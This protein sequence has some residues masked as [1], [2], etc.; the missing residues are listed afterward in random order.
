MHANAGCREGRPRPRP[1]TRCWH[2]TALMVTESC[3]HTNQLGTSKKT[4]TYII[5]SKNK[6]LHYAAPECVTTQPDVD[7]IALR[8]LL[9]KCFIS[10]H[11]WTQTAGIW[12]AA[13][14][15]NVPCIANPQGVATCA[16]DQSRRFDHVSSK[17]RGLELDVRTSEARPC[18]AKQPRTRQSV[19]VRKGAATEDGTWPQR[20]LLADHASTALR[21]LQLLTHGHDT[22]QCL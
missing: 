22:G 20:L 11:R 14:C 9:E 15:A 8:V 17:R 4:K 18:P 16:W 19:G 6:N 2:E 3:R 7:S 13:Q 10:L 5:T 12:P 1:A 21:T